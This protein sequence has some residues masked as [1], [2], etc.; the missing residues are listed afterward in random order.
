MKTKKSLGKLNK[1]AM[2][3]ITMACAFASVISL[4]ANAGSI[5]SSYN[6]EV[7]S[8]ISTK[9]TAIVTHNKVG[10]RSDVFGSY[11]KIYDGKTTARISAQVYFN[12]DKRYSGV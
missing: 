9:D 2:T 6:M 10:T 4:H 1:L 7:A 5:S 3:A 12:N 11:P 8:R